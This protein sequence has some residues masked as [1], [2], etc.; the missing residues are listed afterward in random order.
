MPSM[1]E[2]AIVLGHLRGSP[3]EAG[4]E[5][6]A[7]HGPQGGRHRPVADVRRGQL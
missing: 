7:L 3:L 2:M 6:G 4:V 5:V 1:E